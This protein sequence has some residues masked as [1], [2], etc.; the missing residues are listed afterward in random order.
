MHHD[1]TF[2]SEGARV[3]GVLRLP[4][5]GAAPYPVVIFCAG[6]SLTK[7]VWLPPY[8]EALNGLGWATLN[9]DYRGFGESE[10]TPRCR[11]VP[12]MQVDDV[13][14]AVTFLESI[15]DIDAARIG[16][17]GVS[18]GAAIALGAAG[19]DDRIRAM[20]A[21]AG[22]SDLWRVW[23]QLPAF[24]GF[25][26][27]VRAARRR[28]VVSGDVSYAPVSKLLS[29]DPET[30]QKILDDAPSFP[31]WRPEIT[32]ESLQSLFEFRPE[33]V[34]PFCRASCFIYCGDDALIGKN[35]AVS[36]WANAREPKQLVELAGVRHAEIYGQGRG[37][38]PCLAAIASFLRDHLAAGTQAA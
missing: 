23:S 38:A 9:F 3:A 2:I 34:A 1:V 31:H 37:F 35:E 32:F 22:P 15:A 21:V 28:F 6:F 33:Q 12:T 11:L 20:V 36:A 13:R 17:V 4:A 25:R 10:G 8:A 7:E 5:T 18:L 27:K 19:I 16:V 30:C 24:A 26:D 29:S 14:N